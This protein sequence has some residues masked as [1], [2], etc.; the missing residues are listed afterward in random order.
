MLAIRLEGSR[1]ALAIARLF[2]SER[3]SSARVAREHEKAITFTLT[4]EEAE[5]LMVKGW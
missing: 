1:L 2:K 5:L 3:A 4:A